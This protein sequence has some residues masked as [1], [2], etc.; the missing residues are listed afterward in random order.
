MIEGE[1][2]RREP[3]TE[4]E[5][6]E[7]EDTQEEEQEQEED[8]DQEEEED[9]TSVNG[10]ESDQRATNNLRRSARI[11]AQASQV[12]DAAMQQIAHLIPEEAKH[13]PFLQAVAY[14]PHEKMDY[15]MVLDLVQKGWIIGLN[16]GI[17]NQEAQEVHGQRRRPSTSTRQRGELN[18][19]GEAETSEPTRRTRTAKAIKNLKKIG[20]K[21]K[22]K[23]LSDKKKQK[24]NGNPETERGRLQKG[25][26]SPT[27]A[28]HMQ[29]SGNGSRTADVPFPQE[30]TFD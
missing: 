4:E 8:Q 26:G 14:I 29:Q 13:L 1:I 23:V 2:N 3:Q 25:N 17:G 7:E 10:E 6:E 21:I 15:Y 24:I 30:L 12:N 9:D 5:Q 11:R 28:H 19:A 18:N 22:N 27:A 16:T 20:P